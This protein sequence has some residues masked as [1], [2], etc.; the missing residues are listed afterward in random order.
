MTPHERD[1][2][3]MIDAMRFDDR[4]HRPRTEWVWDRH[5]NPDLGA[6]STLRAVLTAD[7]VDDAVIEDWLR[8]RQYN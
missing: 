3:V 6:V 2:G 4:F 7:T 5:L 8:T 1:A